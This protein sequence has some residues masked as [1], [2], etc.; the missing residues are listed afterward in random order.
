MVEERGTSPLSIARRLDVRGM[1]FAQMLCITF[2]TEP[3][4]RLAFANALSSRPKCAE[5]K[6]WNMRGDAC[7]PKRTEGRA[8]LSKHIEGCGSAPKCLEAPGSAPKLV[9]PQGLVFNPS[10]G[11]NMWE[12]IKSLTVNRSRHIYCVTA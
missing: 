10:M 9:N 5:N 4:I 12:P 11:P 2:I 7:S 1:K 8:C 3:E 6:L